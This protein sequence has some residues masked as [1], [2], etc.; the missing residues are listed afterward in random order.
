MS[1]GLESQA[2]F[3]EE[4]G[5]TYASVAGSQ[6]LTQA[7]TSRAGP[8]TSHTTLAHWQR[9]EAWNSRVS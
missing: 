1:S 7:L 3:Q 9:M 6:L 5:Y 8:Y 4:A 2:G